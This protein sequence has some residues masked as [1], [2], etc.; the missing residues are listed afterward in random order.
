MSKK[1]NIFQRLG[2]SPVWK[3]IF[4]S[5]VPRTRRQRMMSVLNSVFLH[6]HPV[7]LPRH[8]V[9]LKFTWCMGGLTFFLYLVL[10]ITGILLMFYYRP[11]V[12][13]AYTDII[14]LREQVPLGIMR[15]IH[16]WGAH[17]MVITV[18]LHMFRVFMTGS[19]KPPREF[20]WVVGVILLFLTLLLSFTGY[21]L[22]WDQLAIW[23]VTVGTNMA[24]ATPFL[25]HEGPGAALLSLGDINFVHAASDIRFALLGGRFVGES[26]LLRF[27]VLHC[28]GLPFIIMIFMAVHFWRVRKDGGISG[29]T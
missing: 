21:L 26:A 9:K 23:A 13:Y 27:Y 3:S 24:R 16:R 22:P 5:G 12:E 18:W 15:E 28:I 29:P 1:K 17:A 7:R 8:A 10:T 11:T 4:R 2:E 20:N 14:D 25:G 19:Y 6:L